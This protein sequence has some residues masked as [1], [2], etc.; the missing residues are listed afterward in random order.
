MVDACAKVSGRQKTVVD[1]TKNLEIAGRESDCAHE[2]KRQQR[3]EKVFGFV[4]LDQ[5]CRTEAEGD[6][7]QQLIG[8]SKQR[9]KR[10]D[11]AKGIDD[12]LI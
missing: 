7:R 5:K 11:A 3:H 6:D 1:L 2:A 9:P 10:V 12:A 8:E 4:H